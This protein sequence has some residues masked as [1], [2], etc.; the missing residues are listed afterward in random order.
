MIKYIIC[1][2]G[3]DGRGCVKIHGKY[4]SWW[5]AFWKFL[6]LNFG[7][8]PFGRSVYYIDKREVGDETYKII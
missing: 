1:Q 4:E 8:I 5:S 2:T 3:S 6:K 7:P